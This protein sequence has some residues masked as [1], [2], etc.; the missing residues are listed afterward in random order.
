GLLIGLLWSERLTLPTD[1]NHKPDLGCCL[2]VGFNIEIFAVVA[3]AVHYSPNWMGGDPVMPTLPEVVRDS[4]VM[5]RAAVIWTLATLA[6]LGLVITQRVKW[7]WSINLVAFA[8]FVIFTLIPTYQLADSLRQ[9]PLREIAGAIAAQRQPDEPAVMVG[10]MKPS[11]V[12]YA[13]QPIT[14]IGT[15][16]NVPPRLRE[17]T[18]DAT[19]VLLV[20][21]PEEILAANPNNWPLEMLLEAGTYQL[22][23]ATL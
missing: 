14:Y 20:G 4:G 10:F 3:W 15:P 2:R 22:V 9:Q 13:E 7:L 23:R 18:P 1:A 6:A 17:N 21:H 11:L 16:Q 19:S 12:F 5:T 8:A